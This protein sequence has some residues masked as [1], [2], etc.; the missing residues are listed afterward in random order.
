GTPE[1]ES[2]RGPYRVIAGAMSCA[3]GRFSD[4]R[5]NWCVVVPHRALVPPFPGVVRHRAR[6]RADWRPYPEDRR[7][8]PALPCP[9]TSPWRL[10][11]PSLPE[12]PG[13]RPL[14]HRAPCPRA[15]QAR[16]AL[17]R[18]VASGPASAGPHRA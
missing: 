9:P 10:D 8:P 11:P 7:A 5:G 13:L 17:A 18:A 14:S 3:T 12:R 2:L 4:D 16:P 6:A 15:A 1:G